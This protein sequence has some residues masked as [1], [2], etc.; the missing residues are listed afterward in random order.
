MSSKDSLAIRD[1]KKWWAVRREL[2]TSLEVINSAACVCPW[3]GC[4]VGVPLGGW[5]LWVCPWGGW[6]VIVGVPLGGCGHSGCALCGW[7]VI[8]GV[9]L[10]GYGHCGCVP[11][12][13]CPWVA[14][15][16]GCTCVYTHLDNYVCVQRVVLL[17]ISLISL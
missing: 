15:C 9:P 16:C 5:S 2:D 6:V 13:V 1:K 7:V 11:G 10:D 17:C 12:W 4:I 8:V 3:G 14:M